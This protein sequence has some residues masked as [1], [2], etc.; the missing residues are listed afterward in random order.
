VKER[1]RPRR[2][3]L[4]HQHTEVLGSPLLWERKSDPRSFLAPVKGENSCFFLPGC[5][6]NYSEEA[7]PTITSIPGSSGHLS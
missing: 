4:Y 7:L 1:G 2:D 3:G 6:S 5:I